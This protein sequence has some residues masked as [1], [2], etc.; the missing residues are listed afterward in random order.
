MMRGLSMSIGMNFK[1]E[2]VKSILENAIDQY[3]L[4]DIFLGIFTQS[5][6]WIAT[7]A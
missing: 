7:H 2:V 6:R 4:F 1:C 5:I 3:L